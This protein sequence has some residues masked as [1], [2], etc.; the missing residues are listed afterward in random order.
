MTCGAESTLTLVIAARAESATFGDLLSVK[1][2]TAEGKVRLPR[3]GSPE[4]GPRV[5]AMWSALKK[6]CVPYC[7]ESLRSTSAIVAS[8]STWSGMMSILRSIPS[9]TAPGTS[10]PARQARSNT[11]PTT[12]PPETCSGTLATETHR[13]GSWP[14][15][16]TDLQLL[17]AGRSAPRRAGRRGDI[18]WRERALEEVFEIGALAVLYVIDMPGPRGGVLELVGEPE[19]SSCRIDV[20]GLRRHDENGIDPI[21]RNDAHDAA[22]STFGLSLQHPL[23]LAGTLCRIA[24]AHGK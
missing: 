18:A 5:L 4:S 2:G 7:S 24:I 14:A 11:G 17:G 9:T 15:P 8:I 12:G 6:N 1:K 21:H 16:A 20:A 10:G 13:A 3:A 22:K 23:E 19:K